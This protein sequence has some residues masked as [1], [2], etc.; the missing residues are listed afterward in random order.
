MG[1]NVAPI[2]PDAIF[3]ADG[4]EVVRDSLSVVGEFSSDALEILADLLIDSQK[5]ER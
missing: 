5:L 4:V 2:I 1:T 3:D